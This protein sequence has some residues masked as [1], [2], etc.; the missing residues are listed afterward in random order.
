MKIHKIVDI[1]YNDNKI[2]KKPIDT[3]ASVKIIKIPYS[4]GNTYWTTAYELYMCPSCGR[5]K[6]QPTPS[7]YQI[8]LHCGCQL[9]SY[10][11]MNIM[12]FVKIVPE[13]GCELKYKEVEI[14]I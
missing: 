1:K 5:A 14:R 3:T 9:Y 8:N 4:A 6:R 12:E 13:F 11:V 10:N 7:Y 2:N